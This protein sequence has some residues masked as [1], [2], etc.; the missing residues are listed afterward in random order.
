MA[1]LPLAVVPTEAEPEEDAAEAP[2]AFRH[3]SG[4]IPTLQYV[5][6]RPSVP[7]LSLRSQA[8][9]AHRIQPPYPCQPLALVAAQW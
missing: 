5:P 8:S 3:T 4:I 7:S 2:T 6:M 9:F 1:G